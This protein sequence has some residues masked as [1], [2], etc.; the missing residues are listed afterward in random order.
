[1]EQKA[2]N[3]SRLEGRRFSSSVGKQLRLYSLSI[4]MSKLGIGI[5]RWLISR[6]PA[7][8][9]KINATSDICPFFSA[10]FSLKLGL[11]LK[12][13]CFARSHAFA[14]CF[15]INYASLI[16]RMNE[17]ERETRPWNLNVNGSMTGREYIR[18]SVFRTSET[19]IDLCMQI[20][21]PFFY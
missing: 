20:E 11:Q 15:S 18:T 6:N 1:M 9:A 3:H 17:Q 10:N 7:V 19:D 14:N 21:A 13:Y 5:D 16:G 8:C 4:F 2:L 12:Y